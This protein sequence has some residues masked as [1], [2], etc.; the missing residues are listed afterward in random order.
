MDSQGRRTSKQ[1]FAPIKLP[2][3]AVGGTNATFDKVTF[4][5]LCLM[6][7]PNVNEEVIGIIYDESGFD[8]EYSVQQV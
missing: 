4:E 8:C 6:F 7:S 2:D 5:T 1:D 3:G